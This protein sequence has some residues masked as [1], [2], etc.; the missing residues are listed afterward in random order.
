MA[1]G[2][3]LNDEDRE[4]WLELVRTAAHRVCSDQ[5][6]NSRRG[7][8]VACSALK[9]YYRDILRGTRKPKSLK[10]TSNVKPPESRNLPTYFVFI[11]G[12][13]GVLLKR[14]ETRE[15]HF[16]KAAMLDSQLST[17]E[18]PEG[19][20][21]VVTIFTD[22]G[23]IEEKAQIAKESLSRLGVSFVGSMGHKL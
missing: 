15:G 1:G 9:K 2:R 4:P 3:P 12:E 18:N 19:E 23:N 17:L 22:M 20:E 13:R 10:D 16:M 7:V 21:G 14:M 8:V 6:N 11:K 5:K